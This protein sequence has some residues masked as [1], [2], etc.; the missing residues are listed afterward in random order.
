M[1]IVAIET[2]IPEEHPAILWVRIHTD[3]G[4]TGLGETLG[5]AEAAAAAVHGLAAGLLLNEDPL[6]IELHWHRIFRA[7]NYHGVGGAELRALSAVDIALWDILGKVTDQPIHALLGGACRQ[8]IP[9]YNTCGSYGAIRDRERF[10]TDPAG[11]S[12]EL[13]GEGV[14]IMKIWPF[15]EFA[16]ATEGQYIGPDALR[17]GGE[18]VAAIR[19]A[20]GDQIEIAIEGHSLWNLPSAIRIAK[21]LE[22]F[23]PFWL[24]DM[25]W[26]DNVDALADLR[27]ATSIPIIASERLTTRW[28]VRDLIERGAADIVMFDPIWTGGISESR[29]IATIASAA[30]LPVAPHNCGGPITHVAVTHFCAATYNLLA[31]ETIRAFY[32]GFFSDL[33]T[34]VPEPVAG[35]IPLPRGPGLGAELREEVLESDTLVRSMTSH[36][37]PEIQGFGAGDPWSTQRF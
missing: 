3:A 12:A 28:R 23:R 14:K 1:R 13:V 11:L 30:Q 6:Q 29:K 16:P 7:I 5:Q 31:M 4:V 27:R 9:T 32:R 25:I 34:Y 2:L 24:E 8:Q 15:D 10:L 33:V 20:V 22:P 36:R 26:P 17:V 37:A 18:R 19:D 21:E 35:A